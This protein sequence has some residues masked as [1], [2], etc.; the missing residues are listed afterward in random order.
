D[1]PREKA[2]ITSR[3]VTPRS[4]TRV[5]SRSRV[6]RGRGASRGPAARCRPRPRRR[7][8]GSTARPSCSSRAS[9]AERDAL[10]DMLDFDRG[11]A[12]V[13]GTRV[14]LSYKD[15]EALPADGSRY[16]LHEGELSVTPAPSPT[17]QRVI[18]NL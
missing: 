13:T 2:A 12:P 15:Y 10:G 18:R 17:H 7:R 4:R 3:T 16:E 14:I 6:G 9:A 5:T 8:T 11:V 1:V